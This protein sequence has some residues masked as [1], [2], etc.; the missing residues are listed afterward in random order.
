MYKRQ[1][2]DYKAKYTAGQA[3]HLVPA[4]LPKEAY[5]EVLSMAAR[6]HNVLG[7]RGLTRSDFRYD[8]KEGK[9][10]ILEIN[11]QPGMT[12]L[13]LAPEIAA[14]RGISYKELVKRL[15]EGALE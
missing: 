3:E 14:W 4:P 13:S 15:V 2:Y 1:F 10:Y 12:P 7:C 5:D 6:A 9:L 11:T 8:D